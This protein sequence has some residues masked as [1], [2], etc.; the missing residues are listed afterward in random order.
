[1]TQ[2]PAARL[3]AAIERGPVA[4]PGAFNALAGRAIADA[5]FEGCYVSG[6][7]MSV[8]AGVPDVGLLTLTEFAVEIRRIADASGL[9]VIADADT[10]FGEYEQALRTV[11]DGETVYRVEHDEELVVFP[12]PDV[13]VGL[14]A[15]LMVTRIG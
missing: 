1:M 2:T 12:N 10:G 5:G 6:A 4:L 11:V 9:P 13:R 3:R 15:G 8:S 14:R 7:A